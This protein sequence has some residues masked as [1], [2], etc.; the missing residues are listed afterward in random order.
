MKQG[1]GSQMRSP[2]LAQMGQDQ[3]WGPLARRGSRET[4]QFGAPPSRTKPWGADRVRL[5]PLPPPSCVGCLRAINPENGF[6]GVAPGTST[7]TNPN[8]MHTIQR[9]TIFTNVAET[10]EGGVYWEGIDQ[11]IPAGVTISTWQGK[12]WQPGECREHLLQRALGGVKPGGVEPGAEPKTLGG[13]G[14]SCKALWVICS[15]ESSLCGRERKIPLRLVA[16]GDSV[17]VCFNITPKVAG[18]DG[19]ILLISLQGF[20][21]LRVTFYLL[22]PYNASFAEQGLPVLSLR[23][24]FEDQGWADAKVHPR[25]RCF[26]SSAE[27]LSSPWGAWTPWP[28]GQRIHFPDDT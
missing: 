15:G 16:K 1:Q 8:A 19:T 22:S 13:S 9:N 17:C 21:R 3:G 10:S 23:S 26:W 5:T 12:P 27:C 24:Y 2:T 28:L 6:F 11:M 7:R 14:G 25:R 20:Y 18:A 4:S